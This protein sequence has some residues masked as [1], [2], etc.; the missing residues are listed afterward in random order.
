MIA[1]ILN[2]EHELNIQHDVSPSGGGLGGKA[3]KAE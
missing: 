2:M 1:E 3:A